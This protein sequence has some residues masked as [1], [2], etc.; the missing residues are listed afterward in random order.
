MYQLY[1]H[2][3]VE[4]SHSVVKIKVISLLN[5]I[6]NYEKRQNDNC[7]NRSKSFDKCCKLKFL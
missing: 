3:Q 4:T 7:V 5:K 1:Y 2:M 6:V